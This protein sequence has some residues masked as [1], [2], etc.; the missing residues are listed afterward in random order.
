MVDRAV[1]TVGSSP[2]NASASISLAEAELDAAIGET[3]HARKRPSRLRGG[4]T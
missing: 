2:W 4:S 1:A 3:A